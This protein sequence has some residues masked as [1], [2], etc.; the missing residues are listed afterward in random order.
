MSTKTAVK[1]TLILTIILYVLCFAFLDKPITHFFAT[2]PCAPLIHFFNTYNGL[3]APKK[4]A[5]LGTGIFIIGLIG[6]F[7]KKNQQ[8]YPWLFIGGTSFIMAI[9]IMILKFILGRYRPEQWIQYGHYGFHWFATQNAMH[10]SP[11][12]HAGM[13]FAFFLPLGL[14]LRQFKCGKALL[15]LCCIIA[16]LNAI[17]RVIVLHHFLGDIILGA[18]LSICGTLLI[19]Q[20][21]HRKTLA[22]H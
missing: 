20:Y 5:L 7:A 19:R 2:H 6:H 21:L 10:S 15:W 4:L 17:G 3:L 12:G 16:S 11:S 9:I 22:N 13:A 14:W 18:G 8:A 1:F